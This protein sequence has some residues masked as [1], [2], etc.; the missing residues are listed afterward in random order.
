MKRICKCGCNK[1]TLNNRVYIRG[2]NSRADRISK[3][4][5]GKS[6]IDRYGKQKAKIVADKISKS[7]SNKKVSDKTKDRI[8]EKTKKYSNSEILSKLETIFLTFDNVRK[9]DFY[10]KGRFKHL[11]CHES[12]LRKRFGSLDN[13]AKYIGKNFS[14]TQRWKKKELLVG[15]IL[16]HLHKNIK[17]HSYHPNIGWSDYETTNRV[18][19]VKSTLDDI[20]EE[21]FFRYQKIGKDVFI[22][23]FENK[24]TTNI[25]EDSI[26][27]LDTL[28][29][30]L[31]KEI[32]NYFKH[33]VEVLQSA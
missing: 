2:H 13:A 25:L 4:T 32:K 29:D 19:D 11:V 28:L 22:I 9:C 26:I 31:P 8:R 7:N 17:Y 16:S 1:P 20:K 3:S 12:V 30:Q 5:K 14:T 15:E 27:N 21:Q 6:Y 10:G 23:P 18:Y 33:K 24:G